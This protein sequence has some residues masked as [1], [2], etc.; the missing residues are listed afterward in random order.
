VTNNKPTLHRD[1]T[2]NTDSVSTAPAYLGQF[3]LHVR[4]GLLELR[5]SLPAAKLARIAG[6]I[7]AL[8]GPVERIVK[9]AQETGA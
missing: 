1:A 6:D 8:I 4:R 2:P 5:P 9:A 3:V 7:E